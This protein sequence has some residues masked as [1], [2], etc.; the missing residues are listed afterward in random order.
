MAYNWR[1]DARVDSI[2]E[3]ASLEIAIQRSRLDS[4]TYT[5]DTTALQRATQRSMW[6]R[7]VPPPITPPP[8]S[9][10]PPPPLSDAQQPSL[11]PLPPFPSLPPH[12]GVAFGTAQRPSQP[13]EAPP[14][15]AVGVAVGVQLGTAV[16]YRLRR[17]DMSYCASATLPAPTGATGATA[18]AAPAAA[19]AAADPAAA[20]ASAPSATSSYKRSHDHR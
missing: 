11:P 1:D 13:P 10:P 7:G 9:P 20:A 4:G 15:V 5:D 6:P 12:F 3:D 8:P 16:A 14:G 19:A 17:P 2:N 18:A